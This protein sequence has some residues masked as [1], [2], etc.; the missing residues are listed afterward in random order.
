MIFYVRNRNHNFFRVS[1]SMIKL[2]MKSII[3]NKWED[4]LLNKLR[5]RIRIISDLV[6]KGTMNIGICKLLRIYKYIWTI[7]IFYCNWGKKMVDSGSLTEAEI[8]NNVFRL[9][10]VFLRDT[11]S[12]KK[13][14][15]QHL[16][17]WL[18]H[19]HSF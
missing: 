15:C 10:Y 18:W 11:W 6:I 14:S 7:T 1:R 3:N 8:L 17:F 13:Q 19:M 5:N 9:V 16:S 2:S 4:T 12:W